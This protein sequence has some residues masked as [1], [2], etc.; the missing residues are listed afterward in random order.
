MINPIKKETVKTTCHG[1]YSYERSMY[2]ML[3]KETGMKLA[4][5]SIY[6]WRTFQI[7]LGWTW[8]VRTHCYSTGKYMH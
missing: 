7:T 8:M 5:T 3:L 6:F 1:N 4:D 2:N